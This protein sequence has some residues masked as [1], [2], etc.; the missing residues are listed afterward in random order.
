MSVS[1]LLPTL[2]HAW[3]IEPG[4]SCPKRPQTIASDQPNEDK[5]RK[6]AL[7]I[8]AC[9]QS[10]KQIISLFHHNTQRVWHRN[11]NTLSVWTSLFPWS[12][13][14]SFHHWC[15]YAWSNL[16][17]RG[18]ISAD[19]VTDPSKTCNMNFCDRFLKLV[20]RY[21]I[22]PSFLPSFSL[23]A[24]HLFAQVLAT[25]DLQRWQL[26]SASPLALYPLTS[27]PSKHPNHQL[28]HKSPSLPDDFRKHDLLPLNRLSFIHKPC[29]GG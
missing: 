9:K 6:T 1:F 2:L 26:I 23:S 22:L 8:L 24:V 15:V 13:R 28:P 5:H 18:L 4:L 25:P 10:S 14:R 29:E 11:P 12:S 21:S 16:G 27:T 20:R 7:T 19:T 3:G 17:E